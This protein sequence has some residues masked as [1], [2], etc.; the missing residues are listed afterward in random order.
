MKKVFGISILML[1]LCS[2]MAFA[3]ANPSGTAWLS[4]SGSWT[5]PVTDLAPMPTGTMFLYIQLGNLTQLAGCEFLLMWAPPGPMFSGC[6]ELSVGAHPSGSGTNCGWLMRGGQVEGVNLIDDHSWLIAFAGDECNTVCA[7]GNV[8]RALFDFS[9]CFDDIPGI[10][11]LQYVKVTDC[12]AV[13]DVLTV[14]GDAT[15]IGGVGVQYPCEISTEPATWGSIKA[16]Y[17]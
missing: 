3:G 17:Q 11:C 12:Q 7:S 15:V 1:V 5:S 4:W 9:F 13:I 10:F 6:Y 8:A 14:T 16:L 2:S